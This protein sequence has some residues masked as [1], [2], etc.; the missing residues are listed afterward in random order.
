MEEQ[1]VVR[2]RET[3]GHI[4]KCNVT[5]R[6]VQMTVTYQITSKIK[7]LCIKH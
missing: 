7:N 5:Q 3:D 1:S 6:Y 4:A 2:A